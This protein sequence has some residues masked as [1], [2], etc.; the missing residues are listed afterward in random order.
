M[1]AGASAFSTDGSEVKCG[2]MDHVVLETEGRC[3]AE[4]EGVS[5]TREVTVGA[6]SRSSSRSK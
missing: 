2:E 4:A 6:G 5:A 1:R 3:I